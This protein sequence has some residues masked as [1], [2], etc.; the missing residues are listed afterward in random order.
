MTHRPEDI[1]DLSGQE[2]RGYILR[3]RIGIG[4]FGVVYLAEQPTIG[5]EVAIK[6]ILPQ[7]ANEPDFIR[8]FEREA[9][10][11]ARLEHPHIVPL[12][13]FWRDPGGAYI[14]M[15]WLRGGS[16][17][18]LVGQGPLPMHQIMRLLDQI[19]SALT[20]AHRAGVVHRDIK[21]D[22][23]MLDE[24]G[25]GYLADFGIA[26]DITAQGTQQTAS[27]VGSPA[28]LA[29]E[30]IRTE[31]IS[32]RTDI[33][34][35]GVV[36]F[37]LLT[38]S[39]PFPGLP[40]ATLLYKHLREPL[41][42]LLEFLPTLPEEMDL[43][44]QRATMKAPEER[45]PDVLSLAAA[46]EAALP[47][48]VP[49]TAVET[50]PGEGLREATMSVSVDVPLVS[51]PYKGLRAFQEAD[52]GDFFGRE[53]LTE[54]LAGRLTES[55]AAGR[56]L[57]VVGPSGSGKSS[58][59]R[60]GLIPALRKGVLVPGS[61][62]W[63]IAEMFPDVNP[64]RELEAM[65]LSV[66]VSPPDHLLEKL[67]EDTGALAALI[68]Q[69]LP[70]AEDEL[71]LVIDQFEELFTQVP[72]E[73]LRTHFI[74]SLL[75]ALQVSAPRLRVIITLRADFYDRP[76]QYEHLGEWMRQRTEVV[77]PLSEEELR[78]AVVGPA[79]RIGL[80]VENDLVEAIIADV[81]Q[82]IGS[83]PL[84]Q[85]ALTELFDRR[86]GRELTLN[87]YL[88]SGGVSGALA[89]RADDLY[90]QLDERGREIVRQVF[91]RLVNPGEGME[92]TR[93]RVEQSQLRTMAKEADLLQAV[94]DLF[95]KHRL[96]TFDHDPLT[97]APTV[98]IAHESL[99][100]TWTRLQAWLQNSRSD[101]LLQ[102]R[103][104][105]AAMDWQAVNRDRSFL[106][107]GVR[108]AQF[109]SLLDEADLALSKLEREYLN[110]SIVARREEEAEEAAQQD[111]QR[112]LERQ[113]INRLRTLAVVLLV[114][115]VA[116]LILSAFAL[117]AQQQADANAATAVANAATATVAQGQ[118]MF[119]A[120]TATIAQGEAMI[121]AEAAARDA[122]EAQ[123]FVWASD[124]A[125]A[126]EMGDSGLALSL[127]LA[128]NQF[129]PAPPLAQSVLAEAAYSPGPRYRL[130][131]GHL[132]W[133]WDVVVSPDGKF[134]LSGSADKTMTLWNLET[135]EV[136]RTFSGHS[137]S[138]W[139]VT[140]S[141][142]GTQALSA[143]A[144]RTA[145]LWDIESGA[146]V[147]T[148]SGHSSGVWS[149]VFSPDGRLAATG[150]ADQTIR[151]WDLQTGELIRV[152]SGHSDSV[153]T[154]KFA[155]NGEQLLS[156][157]DDATAI[158]WDIESGEALQ[159]F[160]QHNGG[161]WAVDFS[162]RDRFVLTASFDSTM[163]L[164]NLEN[165]RALRTFQGHK[166]NIWDA[167]F[168]PD[169]QQIL[170]ASADKSL[171]L[172][173]TNTGAQLSSFRVH[174]S[175][176]T[177]AAFSPDGIRAISSSLDK[178]LIVWDILSSV[179]I[180]TLTRHTDAVRAVDVSHDG[181]LAVTASADG[182][183]LLWDLSTGQ[184]L[185]TFQ[186]NLDGF[187]SV[188]FS[189]DARWIFS[190]SDTGSITLWDVD[191][192]SLIY[193][194]S[195]HQGRVWSVAVSAD[196]SFALSG[197]GDQ[198]LKLWK[199]SDGTLVHEF[200][201]HLGSVRSVAFVPQTNQA[202]SAGSDRRLI[203]WDIETGEM[204]RVFEGHR[205]G[206]R[207]IVV[208]PDG[209]TTASAADDRLLILWDIETGQRISTFEAQIDRVWS[210][211]FSPDGQTLLTGSDGGRLILWELQS[212]IPLRSWRGHRRRIWD[213]AFNPAGGGVVSSSSDRTA[214]LWRVDSPEGLITWAYENR[215]I[216][217]L[218]CAERETYQLEP[219][220]ELES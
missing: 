41:P 130:E 35:L 220:C 61:E 92:D 73:K 204:I 108:L 193:K 101:L 19:A 182:T 47:A 185:R 71:L 75:A 93:R 1:A 21:P 124:A 100:R 107:S 175:W 164:W 144:D 14:V 180:R 165:G 134:A 2:I 183:L 201:G 136:V 76:L 9:K 54:R 103:L 215:Y 172:W 113:S 157:S 203:L 162:P 25:N 58:V 178:T 86:E 96:L 97:R 34:S 22:N 150:S 219:L 209:K 12:Y 198:S 132:D 186:D 152:L 87:A 166:S 77:L 66:A 190:G 163:I 119:S 202:L 121:L 115:A 111:Y 131:G 62:T 65:L 51:N 199:L 218:S 123:S 114:A 30:Q 69:C 7:Y 104:T 211:A 33:Y 117:S 206:I 210:A 64:M 37:E 191:T 13:D 160:S 184:W 43:V 217:E 59:V 16:L 207:T 197:G 176:V 23:V 120:A 214:A 205:S 147:Q 168:S 194:V 102:R 28:Y 129:Q 44:I 105:T 170:S 79:E 167:S 26:K 39:R 11:V 49:N 139:K 174:D 137:G 112:R 88:K 158:L 153:L 155:G 142:D 110:A 116:A 63:Y 24:N 45:F 128:A 90:E 70:G 78:R 50:K 173:E 148:L 81:G 146:A 18:D 55:T 8:R 188:A 133:I 141:P 99:I 52:S 82:Q 4:G 200:K 56:F 27:V 57:A 177:G 72:D 46:F 179:K 126:L 138:I 118:S 89:R 135:R 84:L 187:R 3:R 213:L 6:I 67:S 106:A 161:I 10:L 74:R 159:T 31:D 29:P 127:A 154:L 53:A 189:P 60:A 140:F 42:S 15:R 212:G 98:E 36:L 149:A 192:G 83:L 216:R 151:L 68:E 40:A 171:I 80:M 169:G 208:S 48:D 122:A 109:E 94:L 156:G 32:P 17:R 196:G 145:I 5:R 143:S 91:L 95:G 125:E 20:I 195:A 181:R 38:G 85:Y